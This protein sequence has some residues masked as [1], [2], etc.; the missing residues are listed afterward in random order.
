MP[1]GNMKIGI[2]V[3]YY[4]NPSEEWVIQE[5]FRR[6]E[7]C[8]DNQFKIY[9]A[10]NRLDPGLHHYMH[11]KEYLQPVRLQDT[12]LRGSLEHI[13]YLDQLK[14][15]ALD[16][17]CDYICTFDVDSWP[18]YDDFF[19]RAKSLLQENKADLMAVQREENG[20]SYLPHPSF[21]FASAALFRKFNLCFGA[22][23][24]DSEKA[25]YNRFL[26]QTK[27]TFDTGIGIGYRLWQQ[28]IPWLKVLRSNSEDYHFLMGGTYGGLVF[29]MGSSSR[30][31]RFRAEGKPWTKRFGDWL[32]S[33]PLLKTQAKRIVFWLEKFF[34]DRISKQNTGKYQAIRRDLLSN[35]DAFYKKLLG[36]SGAR[37]PNVGGSKTA[38]M[39]GADGYGGH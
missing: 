6:L 5:H 36:G 10:F 8:Y 7:A 25:G 33:I 15:I 11:G 28:N 16:D 29:H 39:A 34:P 27:Q 26:Q 1:D 24:G 19:D 2:L 4:L 18:I 17:D 20:D 3:V 22:P 23:S 12:D 21:I 38:L 30:V 35:P 14:S 9:G 32:K 31:K 37:N 13:W